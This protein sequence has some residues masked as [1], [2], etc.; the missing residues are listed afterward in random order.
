[1]KIAIAGFFVLV[2]IIALSAMYSGTQTE[3]ATHAQQA[4]V[5]SQ[6]RPHDLKLLKRT[7][8]RNACTKHAD[9]SMGNCDAIDQREVVIGM[10]A[11][12]ARLSWG[13]PER[14]NSTIVAQAERDQ[15]VYGGGYI[16]VRDGL[17]EAVQTSR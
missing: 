7:V 11:E 1:M 2:G 8:V 9:W 3:M 6:T 17:V 12:Q 13:K 10:T 4:A 5:A 15:W 14:V 16:Y